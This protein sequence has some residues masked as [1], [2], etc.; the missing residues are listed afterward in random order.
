MRA[1]RPRGGPLRHRPGA[2]RHPQGHPGW[3]AGWPH[4]SADAAA[5]LVALDHLWDL[6]PDREELEDLAS[7][8]RRDVPLPHRRW[9]RMMGAGR[10][11]PPHTR[12]RPGHL[13]LGVRARRGLG[14]PRL[15]A[16]PSATACVP[17]RTCPTPFPPRPHERPAPKDPH[18]PRRT[19]CP[20]TSRRRRC[21]CGPT[22]PRCWPRAWS[23]GRWPASSPAPARRRP[24]LVENNE[25]GDRPRRRPHGQRRRPRRAARQR[26]GPR[27][28]RDP[29]ADR[30]VANL[31]SVER[32][33]SRLYTARVLDAV[34]L[35]G[36]GAYASHG[37]TVVNG[38]AHHLLPRVLSGTRGRRH[39]AGWSGGRLRPWGC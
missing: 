19:T 21:R 12:A 13:P 6:D 32:A 29:P 18:E 25:A 8:P 35:G 24:S 9:A 33:S 31:V 15:A 11:E 17:T 34:S 23:T 16:T 7:E 5:T 37:V 36:R 30:L 27:C 2:H 38:G 28:P 39:L 22:S 26:S 4:G 1:A 10:G 14:C 3:R 20:T